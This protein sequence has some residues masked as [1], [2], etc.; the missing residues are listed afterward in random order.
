MAEPLAPA[1]R[2]HHR[3]DAF[4]GSAALA[5]RPARCSTR[6]FAP[7]SAMLRSLAFELRPRKTDGRC[8][9]PSHSSLWGSDFH[10]PEGASRSWPGSRARGP[11]ATAARRTR[12]PTGIQVGLPEGCSPT[13]SAADVGDASPQMSGVR[14]RRTGIVSAAG[15]VQVRPSGCRGIEGRVP[16]R[17]AA[18]VTSA[19]PRVLRAARDDT[20]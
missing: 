3:T 8:H 13:W 5:T 19:R 17:C 16:R 2:A 12:A 9:G 7:A 15:H 20:L 10:G 6:E 1:L 11:H 18:R 14:C 4:S